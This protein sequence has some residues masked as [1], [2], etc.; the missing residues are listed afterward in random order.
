MSQPSASDS[1]S[2][3]LDIQQTTAEDA[4]DYDTAFDSEKRSTYGTLLIEICLD[5][6]SVAAV[7]VLSL[8]LSFLLHHAALR[9]VLSTDQRLFQWRGE[10]N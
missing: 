9:A 2:W 7:V 4:K 10:Q 6:L 1:T 8:L 5:L 3:K